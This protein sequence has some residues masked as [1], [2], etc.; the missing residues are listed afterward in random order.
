[1]ETAIKKM[2]VLFVGREWK[3]KGLAVALDVMQGLRRERPHL[4]FHCYGVLDSDLPKSLG[5]KDGVIFHGFTK[6]DYSGCCLL[7]HPA[8]DEPFGMVVSEARACGVPCL[9]S[10]QVGAA[11]LG[12][13]DVAIFSLDQPLTDWISGG[14]GLIDGSQG[15]PE[16]PWSWDDLAVAHIRAYVDL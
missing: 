9:I 7:I 1:M 13:Q 3:R 8:Q 5:S 14:L 12:F 4:E 6:P 10:D 11:G 2:K 15:A 16:V